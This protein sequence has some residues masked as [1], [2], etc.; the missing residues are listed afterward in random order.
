MLPPE[1]INRILELNSEAHD[2]LRNDLDGTG[3][4]ST[5]IAL[6]HG[7]RIE[8]LESHMP[9]RTRF[10]GQLNT[11]N[12]DDFRVYCEKHDLG[13]QKSACFVG[14]DLTAVCIFD[15]G[16]SEEPLHGDHRARLA[17][18]YTPEFNALR[19]LIDSHKTQRTMA[20]WIEEWAFML[21][22]ATSFEGGEDISVAKAVSAIRTME[23]KKV[24]EDKRIEGDFSRSASVLEQQEMKDAERFPAYM[25]ATLQP[26]EDLPAMIFE[27]RLSIGE[28]REGIVIHPKPLR[29]DMKMREID[30]HFKALI[31]GHVCPETDIT[32]YQGEMKL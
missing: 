28:N 7:F 8:D 22:F 13:G 30:D 5:L 19:N 11:K 12:P 14:S 1:S 24:R 17:L 3:A 16:S 26:A 2:R 21:T 32:V 15:L 18:P 4:E 20:E 31:E 29:W 27:F 9:Q 10:R 6:P 23:L 25:F